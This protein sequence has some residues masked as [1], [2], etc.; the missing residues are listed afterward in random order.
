MSQPASYKP[1]RFFALASVLIAAVIAVDQYTKWLVL[2][3]MLRQ[4]GDHPGFLDWF[5]TMR[6]VAQFLDQQESYNK[7]TFSPWLDFVMV[8]NKGVSFGMF[9]S[10]NPMTTMRLIGFSLCVCMALL[11]W[12]VLARSKL[13]S[14]ALPLMIGG[15]LGNTIDRIRFS[16]VADFIDV[17]VAQRHWPAFNFA[18]SCIC[19][20]AVLLVLDTLINSTAKKA[21]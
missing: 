8:W 4:K 21:G 20:G 7:I 14:V 9:D 6:P 12:L 19:C 10:G 5:T 3:T 15:A 2:E 18:D 1:G 13:L 16:A 17:H 11:V